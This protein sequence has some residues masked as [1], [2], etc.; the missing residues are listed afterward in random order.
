MTPD[1]ILPLFTAPDGTYHFARWRRPIAPVVFGVQDETLALV[2]DALSA[3]ARRAGHEVAETDP[4]QGANL[5]IFFL[6]DWDELSD[7]PDLDHLVPG[8]TGLAARLSREMADHYRQ[9]RYEADGAIRAAFVFVR[10]GAPLADLPADELAL[11][12]ALR[13]ILPFQA[14][15]FRHHPALLRHNDA[16]V[17]APWLADLIRVAYDPILPVAATDQSHALR[18]SARLL[19]NS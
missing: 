7:V 8:M 16:A 4:E 3:V 11:D 19:A 1:Q 12:L 6:R 13:V 9:F 10:I 15:A 2:K 14:A 18:L 5:M 17:V